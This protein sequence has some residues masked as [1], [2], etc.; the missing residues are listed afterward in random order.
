MT[1]ISNNYSKKFTLKKYT[2]NLSIRMW[3]IYFPNAEIEIF[4]KK[5]T[6]HEKT[7]SHTINCKRICTRYMNLEKKQIFSII[8]DVVA[9]G[10]KLNNEVINI[11]VI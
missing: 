3:C 10:N 2:V 1:N 4:I 6:I 11:I 8:N 5:K 9:I 7:K